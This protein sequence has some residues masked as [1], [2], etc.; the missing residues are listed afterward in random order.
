MRLVRLTVVAIVLVTG[1]TA[2]AA[3]LTMTDLFDHVRSTHPL[4]SKEARSVEV[5]AAQKDA[6]AGAQ[7]WQVAIG[8]RLSYAE[9]LSASPFAPDRVYG[10]DLGASV[11][12]LYWSS[13][14]RVSASYSTQYQR[15]EFGGATEIRLPTPSGDVQTVSLVG[16]ADFFSRTLSVA[17]IQPLLKNAKGVLDRLEFEQQ[18]FQIKARQLQSVETEEAFLAY[19]G[20]LF[21]QWKQIEEQQRIM[22]TRVDVARES[23]EL[24]KKRRAAFLADEVD[25]LRGE[26]WVQQARQLVVQADLAANAVRERLAAATIWPELRERSPAFDLYERHAVDSGDAAIDSI[27]EKSRTL[28][29]IR[30]TGDQ[31]THRLKALRNELLADLDVAVGAG[32]GDG[33]R[34]YVDSWGMDQP[35][36]YAAIS[37]RY[38]LG[39]RTA[40]AKVRAAEIA[41]A[42]IQDEL[43]DAQSRLRAELAD[44]AIQLRRYQEVLELTTAQLA[45]AR[46]KTVEELKMYQQ[47]RNSLAFVIQSRDGEYATEL[48]YAELMASYQQLYLRYREL[49]DQLFTLE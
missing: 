29:F 19:I 49:S 11:G 24:V 27:L 8:P 39:R 4:F 30:T 42:Q 37:L 31:L 25:V 41:L 15:Q 33:D 16:P 47:G 23:L 38:P 12:R 45:T 18:D 48:R 9:P 2:S 20:A 14:A 17:F 46:S 26:D 44:V 7:D 3:T 13:G 22:A 10:Y 28:A 6:Y 40:K 1:A 43:A 36:L 5:L 34:N 21:V 32:I 35:N